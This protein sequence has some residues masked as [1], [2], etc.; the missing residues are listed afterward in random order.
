MGEN[1]KMDAKDKI[2]LNGSMNFDE[3]GNEE[4]V[5]DYYDP[6][7]VA[8]KKKTYKPRPRD[9]MAHIPTAGE[10]YG[11]NANSTFKRTWYR[12]GNKECRNHRT[13]DPESTQAT[14]AKGGYTSDKKASFASASEFYKKR[15]SQL[16]FNEGWGLG[17]TA[18][19]GEVNRTTYI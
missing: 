5:M 17:S 2:V 14:D 3:D 18:K 6:V 7:A 12:D 8:K 15:H 19:K 16:S 4:T 11:N 10:L 1:V 9:I 13:L